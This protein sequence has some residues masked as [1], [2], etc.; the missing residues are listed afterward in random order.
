[1][2][3]TSFGVDIK[4]DDSSPAPILTAPCIQD[5]SLHKRLNNAFDHL[6]KN[7][8]ANENIGDLQRTL[9]R[10]GL[11]VED[12]KGGDTSTSSVQI[13]HH[14]AKK[15]LDPPADEP[16]LGY[17]IH[18]GSET[19]RI[20][21]SSSLLLLYLCQKFNINIFLF[22][23]RSKPILFKAGDDRPSIG[24]IR[25]VDSFKG[26]S[27]LMV[28]APSRHISDSDIRPPSSPIQ[29][30]FSSDIPCAR[31]REGKR[32]SK[33]RKKFEERLAPGEYEEY[34]K[35]ACIDTL[36]GR[37]ES[38]V[39]VLS[40][41]TKLGEHATLNDLLKEKCIEIKGKQGSLTRL[42][43]GILDSALDLARS[44]HNLSEDDLSS[45]YFQ[46]NLG[47]V[48]DNITKW[49]SIVDSH[50]EGI[51]NEA[52]DKWCCG[53]AND[54][55]DDA[56]DSDIDNDSESVN[57]EDSQKD[58]VRTCTATLKQIVRPDLLCHYDDIQSIAK[59]RQKAMTDVMYEL[60]ILTLK[61]VHI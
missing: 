6:L 17:N 51:W 52:V 24:Y 43:R 12:Q 5:S 7:L 61:T 56:S 10:F 26:T 1:M 23:S 4:L 36:R 33:R 28:I 21:S 37:I 31:F 44:D 55:S 34:F 53:L 25:H 50:F 59:A 13:A 42:P 46:K 41:E 15:L 8:P 45:H 3:L 38:N 35:K 18:I 2:D 20:P 19:L 27:Q 32:A 11:I 58:D 39:R 16:H 9:L 49:R 48:K 22:S 60:S 29:I 14:F 30:E 57:E 54:D 47:A 40:K